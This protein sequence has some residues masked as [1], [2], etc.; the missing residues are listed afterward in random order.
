M[1]L[2]PGCGLA[3]LQRGDDG[4]LHVTD[5]YLRLFLARPEL[6]PVPESCQSELALHAALLDDPRRDVTPERLARLQDPDARDNWAVFLRLRTRLLRAGTLQAAYRGLFDGQPIDVPPLFIDLL[7]QA[8]VGALLDGHNAM[9]ARAAELLFRPQRVSVQD[10]RVLAGDRDTL[11]LLKDT[12]GLGDLGR[13]LVQA[14]AAV[15]AVDVAV[16]GPDTEA[17]YWQAAAQGRHTLLLDMSHEITQDVGHGLQFTLKNARSGL[18][19]LAGVL[20]RWVAHML[21]VVVRITPLARIETDHWRWHLGL[22]AES[23]ALL[24]ALYTGE[25]VDDTRRARLL[26]LFELRFD[27]PAQMQPAVAGHPVYLGLAHDAQGLLKLKPQNLLLNL[28]LARAS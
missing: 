23:T 27:D 20:E 25:A 24:N 18:P 22:D 26:S 1:P 19:A 4:A 5:G 11:D 15:K 7:V 6:A 17:R 3:E 13:L 16:L 2:W 28:P 10:G 21:G 8:I 12:G 14:K 9:Q